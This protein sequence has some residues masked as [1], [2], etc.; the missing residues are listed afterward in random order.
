MTAYLLSHANVASDKVYAT[1]QE[2]QGSFR[3]Q[4]F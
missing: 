1:I 4:L 2:K 3:F